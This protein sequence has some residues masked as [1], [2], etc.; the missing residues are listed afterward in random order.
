MEGEKLVEGIQSGQALQCSISLRPQQSA[1]GASNKACTARVWPHWT[2][3][4]LL[5][6]EKQRQEHQDTQ[7]LGGETLPEQ[8]GGQ[9]KAIGRE[10]PASTP[11][12]GS[13]SFPGMVGS[14]Q[15][16]IH[17]VTCDSTIYLE[18]KEI[19]RFVLLETSKGEVE[20]EGNDAKAIRLRLL[21]GPW[22]VFPHKA[23]PPLEGLGDPTEGRKRAPA[24]GLNRVTRSL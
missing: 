22:F 10:P 20:E 11:S 16:R 17:T 7:C 1:L 2:T 19:F 18:E 21:Q 12:N 5:C 24:L 14:L 4:R 23:S 3:P 15:S 13:R 9:A 8:V 6:P